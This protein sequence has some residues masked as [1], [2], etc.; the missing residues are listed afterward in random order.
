M[1]FALLAV[2]RDAFKDDGDTR[3]LRL[4]GSLKL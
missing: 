3:R 2:D 4:A 1:N